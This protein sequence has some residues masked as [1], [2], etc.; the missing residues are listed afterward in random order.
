MTL[1]DGVRALLPC[2]PELHTRDV[3]LAGRLRPMHLASC[4]A[5]P[6][7][8]AVG[9]VPA[10]DVDAVLADL[11]RSLVAQLAG[12]EERSPGSARLTIHGQGRQGAALAVRALFV[13]AGGHAV[14][15]VV[16]PL[17][18]APLPDAQAQDSFFEGLARSP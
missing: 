12:R 18:G 10:E 3:E 7:L 2:R 5:G 16:L 4:E 11:R 13:A 17:A 9:S 8:W 15:L 1:P 14:Q 6:A